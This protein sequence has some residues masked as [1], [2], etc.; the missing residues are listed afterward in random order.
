MKQS[1]RMRKWFYSTAAPFL[2]FHQ[3][4]KWTLRTLKIRFLFYVLF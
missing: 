4:I 3:A 2:Y 1:P